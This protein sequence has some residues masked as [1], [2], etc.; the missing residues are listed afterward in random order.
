MSSENGL[1]G[2]AQEP[3][4]SIVIPYYNQPEQLE[5]V[6]RDLAAQRDVRMEIVVV[7]DASPQACDE[8]AAHFREQGLALT[9]LR[10][11]E[12][13]FTLA[14]RLRGMREIRGRWL[15]FMDSDDGLCSSDAYAGA[16]ALADAA[17]TDILH[18]DTLAADCHGHLC[19]WANARPFHNAP[20]H[21][22][23]IFRTWLTRHCVAHSVWNK[24]YSRELY[25][26]VLSADHD[27][28]IF[29][30]EDF[31]L[32][33]YFMFF[34]RSY[35][36]CTLPVYRYMPPKGKAHLAKLAARSIDAMRMYL[37]LPERLRALGLPEE[38]SRR[39]KTYLRLLTTNN[40]GRMCLL[41]GRDADAGG[42][43]SLS[44][45]E[46]LA[47]IFRYGDLRDFFLVLAITNG[48]NAKKLQKIYHK[49]V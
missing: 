17:Q 6:L 41:L 22:E 8:V 43:A 34:A 25:Q 4:L 19:S 37:G 1:S 42:M 18:F 45:S 20:L 29:R 15:A 21:G 28:P 11:P 24:L 36:P 23:D 26:R 35:T 9:V 40:A 7:D 13:R 48:S 30:I 3:D 44:S 38:E 12:R 16:V 14:A 31:Y 2:N 39:L 5:G 27:L 33:T 32:T 46:E 47:P 49:P 10:Q